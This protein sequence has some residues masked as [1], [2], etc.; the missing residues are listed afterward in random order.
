MDVIKP[1]LEQLATIAGESLATAIMYPDE[2]GPFCWWECQQD[3]L[4]LRYRWNGEGNSREYGHISYRR[5]DGQWAA[6][7]TDNLVE[8]RLLNLYSSPYDAAVS[9]LFHI[10]DVHGDEGSAC[11]ALLY[12]ALIDPSREKSA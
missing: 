1:T 6:I 5:E 2:R 9:L 10:A 12:I 11:H 7:I 4:H 3:F 8:G